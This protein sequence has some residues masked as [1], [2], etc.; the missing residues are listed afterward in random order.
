MIVREV[1]TKAENR[2]FDAT[3]DRV[4]C[5]ESWRRAFNEDV[6]DNGQR[7]AVAVHGRDWSGHSRDG[8]SGPLFPS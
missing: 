5:D 4:S 7:T 1:L 2:A 6:L 3:V 8:G